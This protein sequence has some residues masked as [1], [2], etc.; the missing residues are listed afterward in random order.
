VTVVGESRRN[1]NNNDEAI[2]TRSASARDVG[3]MIDRRTFPDH[4][5]SPPRARIYV[6]RAVR[7]VLTYHRVAPMCVIIT[8]SG[9][10]R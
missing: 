6:Y 7:V 4:L 2:T 1:S 9:Q 10:R 8:S 3:A 5:P